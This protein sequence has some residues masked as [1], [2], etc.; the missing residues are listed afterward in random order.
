[1]QE[2][3]DKLAMLYIQ[4]HYDVKSMSIPEFLKVFDKTCNEIL[5]AMQST[6]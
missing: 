1:M 4:N 5:D 6:K 2:R 3:I